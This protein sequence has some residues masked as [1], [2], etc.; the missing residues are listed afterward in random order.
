M[1][2]RDLNDIR[3]LTRRA[4]I[5]KQSR[6]SSPTKQKEGFGNKAE[7]SIGFLKYR[8][9]CLSSFTTLPIPSLSYKAETKLFVQ[10]K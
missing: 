7:L 6:D 9:V 10:L 5:T 4:L 1:I 2:S 3:Y 8:Q